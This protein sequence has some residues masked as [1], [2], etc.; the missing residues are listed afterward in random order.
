MILSWKEV[1]GFSVTA[2]IVTWLL[3]TVFTVGKELL[4][5]RKNSRYDSLR[6]ALALEHFAMGCAR[7]ISDYAD[8]DA[9]QGSVGSQLSKLPELI[10]SKEVDWK[11]LDTA[12]VE[13]ILSLPNQVDQANGS[14]EFMWQIA[15]PGDEVTEGPEQAGLLGYRAF[16][17]AERLRY[18]Y[19]LPSASQKMNR[20]DYVKVLREHHD[21]K[22]ASWERRYPQ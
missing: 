12:L 21:E 19:K 3:N 10:L 6:V 14:I 15:C 16:V 18:R 11:E 4:Q 13:D 17:L 5:K 9:S 20:W 7:A 22:I 1:L 2:G 8:W